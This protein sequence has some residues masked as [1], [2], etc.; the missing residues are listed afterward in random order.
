MCDL[1]GGVWAQEP[2]LQSGE[3]LRISAEE[4]SRSLKGS[5]TTISLYGT[6]GSAS[7]GSEV[8]EFLCFDIPGGGAR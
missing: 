4:V 2:R 3:R 6:I 8:S 1:S 7:L 5:G